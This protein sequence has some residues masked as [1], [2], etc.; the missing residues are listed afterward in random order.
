MGLCSTLTFHQKQISRPRVLHC[1]LV[2]RHR[3]FTLHDRIK[4]KMS[5]DSEYDEKAS[6]QQSDDEKNDDQGAAA[7]SNETTNG[8]ESEKPATWQDLVCL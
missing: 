4:I 5:S 3:A 6:D 7:T 2:V 1:Y 8:G